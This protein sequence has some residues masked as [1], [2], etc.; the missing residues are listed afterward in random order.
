MVGAILFL[1]STTGGGR[2]GTVFLSMALLPAAGV[3]YLYGPGIAEY[4]ERKNKRAE[5]KEEYPEFAMKVS[6]LIRAGFSPKDALEAIGRER[7][8]E[9]NRALQEEVRM[10]LREIRGGVS[11]IAAYER[12]GRRCELAEYRRFSGLLIRDVKRGSATL[13]EEL[14]DEGRKAAGAMRESARKKGERAGTLLL[15][16]MM[17]FLI[18][19]MVM[20]MYPGFMA[21]AVL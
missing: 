9:K 11:E 10:T 3:L 17:L 1:K 7:S 21:I 20:V 6:M 18:I 14:K 4:E 12:F 16:P 8:K 15:F 13:A 5:L 2:P 19:V